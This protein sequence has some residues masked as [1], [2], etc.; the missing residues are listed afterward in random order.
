MG[1][2]AAAGEARKMNLIDRKKCSL[3]EFGGGFVPLTHT[4]LFSFFHLD[5]NF[6]AFSRI[7]Q[8]SIGR[9]RCGLQVLT[10]RP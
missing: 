10:S 1:G 2:A 7:I 5:W 8:S 4:S 9:Y 3:Y 6:M